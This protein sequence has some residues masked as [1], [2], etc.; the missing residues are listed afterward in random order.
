M[1]MQALD[2][3]PSTAGKPYR[4]LIPKVPDDELITS[5]AVGDKH[6]MVLLFMRHNVRIH[7]SSCD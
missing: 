2:K 4:A 7:A 3:L 5:I 6:A 1:L